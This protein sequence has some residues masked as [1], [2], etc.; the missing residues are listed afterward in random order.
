[1][2]FIFSH[3]TALTNAPEFF[4][5]I[6]NSSG[7]FAVAAHSRITQHRT[8]SIRAHTFSTMRCSVA[9]H[10]PRETWCGAGKKRVH[11]SLS[12]FCSKARSSLLD[13]FRE[14][15]QFVIHPRRKPLMAVCQSTDCATPNDHAPAAYFANGQSANARVVITPALC[16]LRF[17]LACQAVRP[18]VG[19]PD[20]IRRLS[21]PMTTRAVLRYASI[22]AD[23]TPYH[24]GA[25]LGQGN[26]P[27]TRESLG[28][29]KVARFWMSGLDL[30]RL[31]LLF[32][33]SYSTGKHA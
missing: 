24:V 2:S 29:K 33:E 17:P 20:S 31:V 6:R 13:A 11:M 12:F 28:S 14:H 10:L 7:A 30:S 4:F 1:V 21:C 26:S 16:P 3:P 9:T 27:A 25:V 32:S 18:P 8:G 23:R 15:P 19:D 5:I 22:V